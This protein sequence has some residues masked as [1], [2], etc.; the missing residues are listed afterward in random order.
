ME[1]HAS[2][3]ESH[4]L[5][6]YQKVQSRCNCGHNQTEQLHVCSVMNI[7]NEYLKMKEDTFLL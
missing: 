6:Y 1:Q 7:K 2:L 4:L 3:S 5:N